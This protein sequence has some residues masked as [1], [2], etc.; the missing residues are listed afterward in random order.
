MRAEGPRSQGRPPHPAWP[1]ARPASPARGEASC[2]IPLKCYEKRRRTESAGRKK[3][4]N[5]TGAVARASGKRLPSAEGVTDENQPGYR[6]DEDGLAGV[7]AGT[8]SGF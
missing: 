4:A 2:F 1:K 7:P 8:F 5:R 6:F 3:D